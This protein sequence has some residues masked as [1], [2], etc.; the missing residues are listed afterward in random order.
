MSAQITFKRGGKAYATRT[1][2]ETQISTTAFS[3][4]VREVA[5][6]MDRFEVYVSTGENEVRVPNRPGLTLLEILQQ[7]SG[8]S[9]VMGCTFVVDLSV[10]AKGA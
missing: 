8:K 4:V 10:E 5:V 7:A 2:D 9:D 1:F 6:G 3:D